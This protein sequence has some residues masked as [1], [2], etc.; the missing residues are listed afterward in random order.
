MLEVGDELSRD[1]Q[2]LQSYI[3]EHTDNA[4]NHAV[5]GKWHVSEDTSHPTDMGVGYYAGFIS[6][7]VK[8]YWDWKLTENGTTNSSNK[9]TTTKF[10]DLAI[11]WLDAENTEKPWFLWLAYNAPHTP[12]H[13]P[14]QELHS[15]GNLV[16]DEDIIA[17]NPL[18]Y[19]MAALEAMDTEIGRLL[20]SIP[21]KELEKTVIIFIGDNG[22]P[23]QVAQYPYS[24]RTVKGSLYQG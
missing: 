23:N 2:S 12:F 10:T 8:S 17:E 9:Y 21:E 24:R 13:A 1:E 22:T 11:D 16:D 15:Q 20:D 19:Y 5:I 14:P 6:G 18:P 7:G 3:D 4:Y